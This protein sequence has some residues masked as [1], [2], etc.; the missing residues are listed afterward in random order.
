MIDGARIRRSLVAAALFSALAAGGTL[1]LGQAGGI[2]GGLLLGAG[3][4]ALP[5]ASWSWVAAR[6]LASRRA[7]ALAVVLLA[8]KLALYGGVLF[9]LVT[10]P[11]VSPVAVMIGITLTSFIVVA[12]ALVGAPAKAKEAA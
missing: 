8:G 2:A 11:V 3:L 1:L 7:R 12:G 6:G 5:F 10:R 9:L 4:G